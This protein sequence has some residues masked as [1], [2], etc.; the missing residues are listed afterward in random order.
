ME[1]AAKIVEALGGTVEVATYCDCAPSSVTNWKD[2][3]S[4]PRWR[5]KALLALARK[6]GVELTVEDFPR[7]ESP[8]PAADAA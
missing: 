7:R 3:N 6:K 5:K 8:V 1:T 2:T 4:I